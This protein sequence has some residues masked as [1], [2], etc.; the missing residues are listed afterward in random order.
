M[1]KESRAAQAHA[2]ASEWARAIAA[3]P[4]ALF[5]DTETTALGDD[6]EICDLGVVRLDG[7]VVLDCLV[8]PTRPIP[9]GA[10]QVHGITD[11]MVADADPWEIVYGRL[12]EAVQTAR[13]I[14]VYN[15]QYD[16]GVINRVC[17]R[18]G[19]PPFQ[20]VPQWHCAMKRFAEWEAFP[21]KWPGSF[22]WFKLDEAAAKFG[23]QPGGHRALADAETARKVVLAMAATG[24]VPVEAHPP[25]E[26]Q[27]SLFPISDPNRF[28]S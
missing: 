18:F 7:T 9:P 1:A 24:V 22:K 6:A 8:K 10:T 5:L 20:D 15:L 23:F 3:D 17:G 19:F 2:R 11:A 21:G 27:P 14:T 28:L 16:F 26:P 12:C 13:S 4:T 25:P